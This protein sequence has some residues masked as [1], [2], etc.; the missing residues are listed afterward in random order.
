M[1]KSYPVEAV[2]NTFLLVDQRESGDSDWSSVALDM[3]WGAD[4]SRAACDGLLVLVSGEPLRMRMF[5]PDGTED[6][7]GNGLLCTAAYAWETGAVLQTAFTIEHHGIV[8]PAKLDVS[9]GSVQ[10]CTVLL[11]QPR[12]SAE[13][14]PVVTDH[15][16][17]DPFE[18][19][20]PDV[21]YVL[22]PVSTGTAHAIVIAG[23]G[24]SE[25]EFRTW[26]PRIECHP[27]FPERTTVDWVT[28]LG[29]NR[30]R[31]RTWERGVGE[32][33]G[34]GTG[35]AAVAATSFGMLHSG[36]LDV[37]SK[38]GVL[39]AEWPGEGPVRISGRAIVPKRTGAFT[40]AA[41]PVGE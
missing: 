19:A 3:C 26:S 14:I 16:A 31:V 7:C 15:T 12:F 37:E 11:P 30:V 9:G 23:Q 36:A 41:K 20:L 38:G 5:N 27:V 17:D 25:E 34:C 33:L 21:P 1:M 24:V 4:R 32:T 6:F 13:S 2:G 29:E 35:A 28:P 8:V 10:R 22:R 39:R 40:S 18:L